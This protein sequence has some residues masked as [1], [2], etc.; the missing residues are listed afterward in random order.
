MRPPRK[1]YVLGLTG[2]IGMGKSTTAQM[3]REMGS[4]VHDAD[5]AVHAL[6]AGEAVGPVGALHPEV[7]VD[8]RVDRTR[9]A[10]A[11]LGRPDR[12]KALEA[13]VHPL[14]RAREEAFLAQARAE[15]R[16]LAVLDIPLLFETGGEARC[17][18]V[19]VVTAP[20]DVQRQR[21]MARSGM[22]EAAL[23][24]ILGR[25]MPD[26]EKRARARFVV[27]TSRG[28]EAARRDVARIVQQ[29]GETASTSPA[30]AGSPED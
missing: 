9:L 7:I 20:A 1:T 16:P 19:L 13:V 12:L 25:Q 22:T 18:G 6:Y 8:G 24:A 27:D 28:L 5:Q 3:F 30:G 26:A 14:V 2:S 4:P 29:I 17:D 21:V 11:V 23:A 10:A 15:G